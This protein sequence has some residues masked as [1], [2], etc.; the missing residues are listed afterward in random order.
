MLS[1]C[2]KAGPDL[3][4]YSARK[5]HL[6]QP[7]I[8]RYQKETGRSV[9]LVTDK[10][11]VLIQRLSAEGELSQADILL[12]VDAGNLWQAKS[13]ELL[14]EMD[15]AILRQAI[16]AHLKDQEMY[17][18]GLSLRV[19]TL[20]YHPDKISATELSTYEALSGPEYKGQLV[21]RTAKKVYNQSLVGMFIDQYGLEKTRDILAGW[22]A[23]LATQV[24]SS[25]TQV[26]QALANGVGSVGIVNSY[27]L[28]RLQKK[29]P[30]FPIRI[31]WANQADGGVHVNVSGAGICRYAPN[32]ETAL[33]FIEW[34][35]L[36]HI[37]SIFASLNMEYP[38]N[39]AS[40]IH[41]NLKAWGHFEQ[42][43]VP[44]SVLGKHQ[45]TAIQ[46][47]DEVGYF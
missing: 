6:I 12:T 5:S 14:Q 29:D 42:S 3:L 47:M 25:D 9:Q 13:L 15:S 1:S 26:I 45:A 46:L 24:Y 31:F 2:A 32:K 16:P 38:V 27:Y 20:V 19:R 40:D 36:P 10:A 4:I 30:N 37:Q 17:W 33:H 34:L 44:L 8:D 21:L 23:N 22:V 18:V 28:A 39:T 7:L 35:S 11:G 41:E 43:Q